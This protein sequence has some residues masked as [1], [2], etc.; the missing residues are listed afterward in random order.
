MITLNISSVD[1]TFR[2]INTYNELAKIGCWSPMHMFKDY[3]FIDKYLS[4]HPEH[5]K[6]MIGV[7]KAKNIRQR[8]SENIF[9][10]LFTV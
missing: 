7:S 8:I 2:T 4:E 1:S 9:F 3:S 5:E 6:N 10:P